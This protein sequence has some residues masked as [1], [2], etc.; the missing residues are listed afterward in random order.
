MD[1]TPPDALSHEE[2]TVTE[3]EPEESDEPDVPDT[4]APET[5]DTPDTPEEPETPDT[6]SVPTQE[7][8]SGEAASKPADLR[9]LWILTL[10]GA[11]GLVWLR[12]V[13]ALRGRLE[14]CRKGHP[15]RR[16]L[17]LWRWLRHLSKADG[18]PLDEDLLALAEKARF[19]QHTITDE[20]LQ[21][22][23]DARDRRIA[24]LRSQPMKKRLW[25]RYGQV[26]Y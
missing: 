6:P 4:P 15:N 16:A 20:E 23:E 1:P 10:P 5:P 26:L 7:G 8:T 3:P 14:R 21:V 24:A 17:T 2:E 12:R 11:V 25:Q 18:I 19:S 13:L 9:W 22:L